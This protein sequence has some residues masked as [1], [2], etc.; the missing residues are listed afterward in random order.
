VG[1]Y[2]REGMNV[3]DV[4]C[5]MGFFSVPLA[6]LVGGT[7]KVVCI[8]LQDKM[9]R[10]L[11]RR[12]EKAGVA[13]RIDARVCGQKSLGIGDIAGSI[14]FVLLFALAHEV[15]DKKRLFSEILAAMKQTG[16]L[17]LAEP[18]GHV[19]KAD[20][21]RTVSTAQSAGF[22]VLQGLEIRRSRAVLLRPEQGEI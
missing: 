8:D 10:G 19:L 4:G 1:P 17:L 16:E 15:P 3:L 14:D 22:E 21:E 13:E 9:I 12:A 11:I 20:F 6:K 2:V 7:G 5:G 18:R